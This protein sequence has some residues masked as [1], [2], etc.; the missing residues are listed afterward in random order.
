MWQPYSHYFFHFNMTAR[1]SVHYSYQCYFPLMLDAVGW[2][3]WKAYHYPHLFFLL[4]PD[5]MW[6]L[7][8]KAGLTKWKAVVVF[9][10]LIFVSYQSLS[11]IRSSQNTSASWISAL[12][13][14][15]EIQWRQQTIL[16]L[17]DV[18]SCHVKHTLIGWLSFRLN[19]VL[20][21]VLNQTSV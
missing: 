2:V 17:D 6:K 8:K 18:Q 1:M 13:Q 10:T 7:Q 14:L 4:G 3:K 16:Y 19:R 20:N 5:T 9:Y 21:S 15:L 11:C 12:C